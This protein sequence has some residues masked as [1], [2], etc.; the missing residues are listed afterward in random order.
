M[1][2]GEVVRKEGTRNEGYKEGRKL[3]RTPQKGRRDGRKQ[4]AKLW[5]LDLPGYNH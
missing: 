2:D 1:S 3:G 4:Q 5:I